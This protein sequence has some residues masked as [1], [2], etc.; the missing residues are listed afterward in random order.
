MKKLVIIAAALTVAFSVYA[1]PVTEKL[2]VDT[3]LSKYDKTKKNVKK[4]KWNFEMVPSLGLGWGKA[5]N[6][7]PGVGT[8]AMFLGDVYVPFVLGVH[9]I[10]PNGWFEF[11]TGAGYNRRT[12]RASGKGAFWEKEDGNLVVDRLNDAFKLKHSRLYIRSLLLPV[13]FTFKFGKDRDRITIGPELIYNIGANAVTRYIYDDEDKDM[14]THKISGLK[15]NR[16][17]VGL[18]VFTDCVLGIPLYFRWQP[19]NI[20][21]GVKG[22]KMGF[23][24]FGLLL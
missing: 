21:D 15:P 5:T 6:G 18:F 14:V 10:S 11:A 2:E 24:S 20:F 4:E 23:Y 3:F 8:K 9:Y 7:D 22:P 13:Q 12:V 1:Q 19:A 17:S 16:L